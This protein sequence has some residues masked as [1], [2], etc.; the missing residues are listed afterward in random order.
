MT[1]YELLT[2]F[3]DTD[4]RLIVKKL[5]AFVGAPTMSDTQFPV[6]N[7]LRKTLQV[8]PRP[9]NAY[10]KLVPEFL[11]Y[12]NGLQSVPV[13]EKLT[14]TE[15]AAMFEIWGKD[16]A[17]HSRTSFYMSYHLSLLTL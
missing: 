17:L 12:S 14:V 3:P 5:G 1:A 16:G 8:D 13:P 9:L 4:P 15:A 11:E 7:E 2:N 10:T 6:P